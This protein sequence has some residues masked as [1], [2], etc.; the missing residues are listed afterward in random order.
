VRLK[1]DIRNTKSKH[2][3]MK[4]KILFPLGTCQS[5]PAEVRGCK[6]YRN[7]LREN[8]ANVRGRQ[9]RSRWKLAGE[10]CGSWKM[11]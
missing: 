3:K 11:S 4:T 7:E 6:V 8:I 1:C 10:T 5:L 9:L 2:L